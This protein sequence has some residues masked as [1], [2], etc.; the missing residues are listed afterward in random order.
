MVATALPALPP[1]KTSER[2]KRE[3]GGIKPV[4]G[5]KYIPYSVIYAILAQLKIYV[6]FC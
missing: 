4:H 5:A 2:H 6:H 3:A 1:Y